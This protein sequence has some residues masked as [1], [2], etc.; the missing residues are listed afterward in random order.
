[1]TTTADH[2]KPLLWE[3]KNLI[4]AVEAAGVTLF[5]WNVDSD[6]LAMDD[7][8]YDLWGIPRNTDVK[9]EDLSAHIHPADRD[10]VRAAFNARRLRGIVRQTSAARYFRAVRPLDRRP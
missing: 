10:R 4:R 5:S 7:R 8:A 6:A 3:P 1:M 2:L 9:F